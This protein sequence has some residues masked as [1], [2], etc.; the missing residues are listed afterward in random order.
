MSRSTTRRVPFLLVSLA[1]LAGLAVTP[2][3]P[4]D[5]DAGGADH[6]ERQV[7]ETRQ[8]LERQKAR[9]ERIRSEVKG[10]SEQ[11]EVVRDRLRARAKGLYR[12]SRA[13]MLPLAGGF[14]ALLE[15]VGRLQRMERLVEHDLEALRSLQGR[16][17]ALRQEGRQLERAIDEAEGRFGALQTSQAELARQ[18]QAAE[19]FDGTFRRSDFEPRDTAGSGQGGIR[20]VDDPPTGLGS[21][22]G[23]Q[24]GRLAMPVAGELRVRETDLGEGPALRFETR[25]G[26]AVRAAAEGRV[27][28][29]DQ[30]APYGRLVIVDHG[31]GYYT[32]YGGLGR[33]DVQVGDYVGK[34]ARIGSVGSD[35]GLVFEVRRRT[36][37]LEPRSWLGI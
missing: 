37:S 15:H 3:P 33:V 23:A 12:I 36:R 30:H 16:A 11:Q 13:G 7:A 5:G 4:A 35:D 26:R 31:D 27:A 25:A 34:S 28:F 18:R 17:E 9:R 2:P 6:L 29:S 24:R 32:V 19:Q 8:D 20:I 21:D 22:F 10:L 14:A 1:A